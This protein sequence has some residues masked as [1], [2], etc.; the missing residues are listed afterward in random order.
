MILMWCIL[1]VAFVFISYRRPS[2]RDSIIPETFFI[3]KDFK[4]YMEWVVMTQMRVDAKLYTRLNG[5]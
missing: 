5:I 4:V 3:I 2:C 1:N